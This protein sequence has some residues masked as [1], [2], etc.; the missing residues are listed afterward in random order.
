MDPCLRRRIGREMTI[1]L[2]QQD[3]SIVGIGT[4]GFDIDEM[5]WTIDTFEEEKDFMLRMISNAIKGTGWG[6]LSYEPR[7]DWVTHWSNFG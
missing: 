3:Q 2:A 1:W 4:V 7:K 6:K 5:P